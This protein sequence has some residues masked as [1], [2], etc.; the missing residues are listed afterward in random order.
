[1]NFVPVNFRNSGTISR[2]RENIIAAPFIVF[3]F[4]GKPGWKPRDQADLDQHIAD[5]LSIVRWLKEDRRWN[6]AAIVHTGNKSIHAWFAHPGEVLVESLRQS[7]DTLGIDKSLIG[8]PEHP[9]RLP[10][11]VHAKSGRTSR[12]LWLR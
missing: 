5:S 11:Q 8:Y 10:G 9:A 2:K 6:L 7:L 1:V 3:D 4:D 12:V